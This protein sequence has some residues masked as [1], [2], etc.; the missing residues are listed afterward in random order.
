[1]KNEEVPH[2]VKVER[3]I[4]HKIK[5]IKVKRIG[6]ILL[7]NCFSKN[8]FEGKIGGKMEV[9]GRRRRR[10]RKLL[11]DLKERSG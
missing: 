3:N 1:V 10:S 2:R 5:R 4:L 11:D 8:V 9:R 7:R 6:L